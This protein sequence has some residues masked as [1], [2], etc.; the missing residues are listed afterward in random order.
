VTGGA[1]SVLL[2]F[3][4]LTLVLGARPIMGLLPEMVSGD[5]ERRRADLEA[6]KLA[7]YR[8]IRDAQLDWRMG[9]LSDADFE[10]R[11]NRL[12]A[13]AIAILKQLDQLD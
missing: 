9:K 4:G 6:A 12:H 7:K 13:E 3:I 11:S 1:L 5:K 8:E 2:A 10:A